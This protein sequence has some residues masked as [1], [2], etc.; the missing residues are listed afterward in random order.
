[1]K[2]F[3]HPHA[4]KL[5]ELVK[6]K[7]D[8][9]EII[10]SGCEQELI[11]SDEAAYSCPKRDCEFFLHK[12]CFELPRKTELKSHPNHPLILLPE[13][14]QCS[15]Y[16]DCNACGDLING[17][18][19]HCQQECDFKLHVKCAFL[20][21]SVDCKAHEH[22]LAVRHVTTKSSKNDEF[23]GLILCGVCDDSVSDAYWSYYCKDCDFC[24]HL[25]CAFSDYVAPEE[26]EK[27]NEEE[28]EDE[29][30]LS[31]ATKLAMANIKAMDQMARLQFQMQMAQLNARTISM[32]FRSNV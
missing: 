26:Q 5:S 11:P 18:S 3:S 32:L 4:L 1:M 10:C 28:E 16:Y 29:E 13:P 14:P 27:E 19:F 24:T 22:A 30:G 6:K 25:Q 12:S 8:G 31:D 20:P 21:E 7:E 9:D 2:H 15:I 17:F 23:G